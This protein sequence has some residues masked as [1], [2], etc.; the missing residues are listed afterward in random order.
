MCDELRSK[1]AD[2]GERPNAHTRGA[3]D[4]MPA[5]DPGMGLDD[6]L[7]MAVRLMGEMPARARREARDPVQLPD[8]RVGSEMEQIDALANG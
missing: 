4:Q 6:Q 2:G 1:P 3:V 8:D 7:G 5:A